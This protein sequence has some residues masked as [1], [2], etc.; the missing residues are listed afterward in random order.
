MYTD[1]ALSSGLKSS[2]LASWCYG[3]MSLLKEY[4]NIQLIPASWLVIISLFNLVVLDTNHHTTNSKL[5]VWWW[6]LCVD[7]HCRLT[8]SG[9]VWI[10]IDYLVNLDQPVWHI[11][12]TQVLWA[13]HH[14]AHLTVLVVNGRG[15][16][17]TWGLALSAWSCPGSGFCRTPGEQGG[18]RTPGRLS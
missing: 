16:E 12:D 2:W 14:G 17:L 4:I 9:L 3:F 5:D 11:Q 13:F 18:G 7:K 8:E 6:C 1:K 10:K 15:A